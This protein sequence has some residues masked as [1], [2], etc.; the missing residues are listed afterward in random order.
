M[1]KVQETLVIGGAPFADLLP[2][3]IRKEH[4]GK[5]TRGKM[6][7]GIL[8]VVLLVFVG[9][10][11]SYYFAMTSQM[12]LI[13][14]QNRTND[15]MLEQQKYSEVRA[16]QGD[17]ATIEAGQRVGTGTEID[18]KAYL[19]RV[20]TTLP[21]GSAITTVTVD[22]ASPLIDY[23]QP[24]GPLQGARVATLSLQ[25]VSKTI[26]DISAWLGALETLPGFV[27]AFPGSVTR[28]D[29]GGSYTVAMV[30]HINE[31][32][33]SQRFVPEE[34]KEAADTDETDETGAPAKDGE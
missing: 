10:G 13:A 1:S 34:D 23:A 15:L 16:V 32:A 29:A 3:E 19:D 26:P 31:N 21:E 25:L 33:W 18:W 14:E 9:T 22:A 17:I 7:W 27:D 28:N 24:T 11:V 5:N 6:L 8:G 30:L 4:Q 2:P 12:A 20:D